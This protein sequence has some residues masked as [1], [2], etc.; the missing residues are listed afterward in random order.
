MPPSKFTAEV[1]P[2]IVR[3][4]ETLSEKLRSETEGNPPAV[5]GARSLEQWFHL[6]S[7]GDRDA[8]RR[9]LSW[10]GLDED[11]AAAILETVSPSAANL[12][13]WAGVVREVLEENAVRT[14]DSITAHELRFY[15]KG[16]E[17]R[18]AHLWIPWVRVASSRLRSRS[19]RVDELLSETALGTLRAHLLRTISA[20]GEAVLFEKFTSGGSNYEA[21]IEGV[22]GDLPRF[23][24]E[25]PVLARLAASLVENWVDA[26]AEFVRRLHTDRDAVAAH[27]CAGRD[28]GIVEE[29]VTGISDRH[30]GNRQIH[31]LKFRSGTRVVYKPRPV[32]LEDRYNRF[33]DWLAH[34]GFTDAPPALVMVPG[35]EYGWVEY[36]EQSPIADS[37]AADAYF[38]AAG[39][40]L[41]IAHLLGGRD[42]HMENVIAT[43]RG[44][45]LVD[46]EALLQPDGGARSRPQGAMEAANQRV[47]D[48]FLATG[49]LSFLQTDANGAV[50]DIGGLCGYGGYTSASKQRVWRDVNTDAMRPEEVSVTAPPEKNVPLLDD[51]P[52]RPEEHI[53]ALVAG[54]EGA[55]RFLIE[56]REG[57]ER[58]LDSFRGHPARI[59]F[60]A[61][62][63]YASV[64][65]HLTGPR[66]LR[67]G[68]VRSFAL[69]SINRVFR[70]SP[71]RPPLWPLVREEREA[72]ERLDIPYFSTPAEAVAVRSAGG[73]LVAGMFARSGL[74]AAGDR[75]RGFSED[76]LQQQTDLLRA[77][78]TASTDTRSPEADR[79]QGSVSAR[80]AAMS[81]DELMTE[82]TAIAERLRRHAISGDDGAVTWIAP[83]Y[84][85]MAERA[86]RGVAYY[87]YHGAA[88]IA[89]FLA[90]CAAITGEKVYADL[91]NGAI[92]PIERVFEDPGVTALLRLEPIGGCNGLGSILYSLVTSSSLLGASHH[93]DLARTVA[94][95]ITAEKIDGDETYDVEGGTAGAIIGLL[96]LH[97]IAADDSLLAA[98]ISCGEHLLRHR[99]S[100]VRGGAAWAASDGLMLG[101]MAHGAAGIAMALARLFSACGQSRFLDAARDALRYERSIFDPADGNW[102][103]LSST[104]KAPIPMKA[105]CHGAPG[106]GLA[107]MGA[108]SVLD[109]REIRGEIEAAMTTTAAMEFSSTDH[110]CCGNAG[111]AEALLA[112]GR[113]FQRSEW[114]RAGEDRIAATVERARKLGRYTLRMNDSDNDALIPG[115]FRGISGIGYELL[116]FAAPERLPSILSFE[117]S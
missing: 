37:T 22:R 67:N 90:G 77:T 97:Q 76:D 113:R 15:E 94:A 10:D 102:P 23:M 117:V 17:P 53:D 115:F 3:E 34:S 108:L 60:R 51:V 5:S 100:S 84:L 14:T 48:S 13:S 107:R 21:L 109:D 40:L 63:I 27:L 12:P 45:V 2:H 38:R 114:V 52:L 91:A 86:D 98:A 9:R 31:I 92:R 47:R 111:Q 85:R 7:S 58:Q 35:D 73:E 32:G 106:I 93:L 11:R 26:T 18:F 88:G 89:V 104:G 82:A 8:F 110:L 30:N 61:S 54:F 80:T 78:L 16:R 20:L 101:G 65:M 33:L 105:W 79:G 24:T 99:V 103:V 75:L 46:G 74:D 95:H 116:R 39:A 96:A 49:L 55:Y 83:S 41:C 36:A 66:Y 57:V 64:L 81:A 50:Y 72:L 44:P 43:A 68:L 4:A 87:L 62:N 112:G 6:Y 28:P 29:I 56:N 69:D 1:L 25:Y 70:R 71:V 59:I 42:L 19:S